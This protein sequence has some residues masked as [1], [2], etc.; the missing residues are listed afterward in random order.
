MNFTDP[1]FIDDLVDKYGSPLFVVSSEVLEHN[2]KSFRK[3]FS[4]KYSRVEIAYAYKANY[5]T[6][7][8]RIIHKEGT[9]AEVASGFEY[10][11][12]KNAGVSGKS[13]IYNG[14]V[15]TKES[16]LKAVEEG[17]LINADNKEEIYLLFE[18]AKERNEFLDIGIRVNMD[19]GIDQVVDRF[20]FSLESG[21]AYEAVKLCTESGYLNVVCLHVHLTSYIVEPNSSDYY[22]PA[23][24]IKLIWP[25]GAELYGKAAVKISKLAGEIKSRLG[26]EI[27]YLDLGG[28]FPSVDNLSPY[29]ESIVEPILTSFKDNLPVLILEPGRAIVR[30]AVSLV[31]TVVSV[32]EIQNGQNVLTVDAGINLLPTS[33]WSVQDVKPIR[34]IKGK[35]KDTIIYGPLCL[36]TDIIAKI[37]LPEINQGDKILVENVGAYNIPQ[38]NAFIYPRPQIVMIDG[39]SIRVIRRQETVEDVLKLENLD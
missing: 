20:G 8:L 7:I 6:E 21:E 2:V 31:A 9:W 22:V 37:S 26:T 25:K 18:I 16:L 28:G 14:P 27:K 23:Q 4:E 3:I 33:F 19:V 17:S 10:D 13:I 15:K 34:N 36:Q 24:N 29:A 39:D 12:A 5:L 1:A 30:N 38:S 32:K 11:I 35:T